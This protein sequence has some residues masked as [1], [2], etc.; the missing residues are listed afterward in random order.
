MHNYFDSPKFAACT[1]AIGPLSS[2]K[3]KTFYS[4]SKLI[5]LYKAKKSPF[6]ITRKLTLFSVY[7]LISGSSI[8]NNESTLHNGSYY[9]VLF[10]ST[11]CLLQ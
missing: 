8:I 3:N 1:V 5:S 9:Y 6:I 11:P 2:M 4:N 10:M 7:C